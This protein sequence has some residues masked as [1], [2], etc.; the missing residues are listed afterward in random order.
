MTSQHH[1]S[2]LHV[3][4]G[5]VLPDAWSVVTIQ[6]LLDAGILVLVQD[7]NHGGNYPKPDEFASTGIPLIKGV[8]LQDGLIDFRGCEFLRPESAAKLRIGFAKPGDVLLTHKGTMGK[9]AIVPPIPWEYI[10]INPQLTLYRFGDESV[11]SRRFLKFFFDSPLFQGFLNRISATSTVS[12]LSLTNQKRLAIPLPPMSEQ[13]SITTVLGALDDKI[14]LNRQMNQT[15]EAIARAIFKSWFVDFDPVRAKMEGRQP[16]GNNPDSAALFPVALHESPHGLVPIGWRTLAPKLVIEYALGGDWGK[17]TCQAAWT[18]PVLCIR[19][20]DIPSLQRGGRGEM[21]T[22]FLKPSSLEKRRLAPG[23]IVLEISGGSP[24]QSTG[25]CVLITKELLERFELPLVYSNF[26]RL[27]RFGR[28]V[29][30]PYAYLWLRWLYA[31][32]AFLQY[33]TG[34]TGIK[35]L[36]FTAFSQRHHLIVPSREVLD[37]FTSIMHDLFRLHQLNG[38]E[39]DTLAQLRDALLP[40]LISG[41]LRVP[42]AERFMEDN[43]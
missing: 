5:S 2:T 9:T 35:N 21:P 12:T 42:D 32:D 26:C 30:P 14:E 34:T 4:E 8:H 11:L 29:S 18:E 39:S 16:T 38:S 6:Q 31:T 13:C 40:K 36:G 7:G 28:A 23:D 3:V 24:T 27:L 41:Q 17:N 25:R 1:E 10:V 22:R 37:S 33:E 20:A 43:L 19:G 15:L